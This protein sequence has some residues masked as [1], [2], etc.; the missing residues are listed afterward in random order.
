MLRR[1]GGAAARADASGLWMGAR[2]WARLGTSGGGTRGSQACASARVTF[3]CGM[4]RA[5]V[6]PLALPV[7]MA[8][9]PRGL[10]QPPRGGRR[11]SFPMRARVVASLVTAW[12]LLAVAMPLAEAM[13]AGAGVRVPPRAM[14]AGMG[15]P[16]VEAC[17]LAMTCAMRT[18]RRHRARACARGVRRAV[19][20]RAGQGATRRPSAANGA[21]CG[22]S[23]SI[24]TWCRSSRLAPS[25]P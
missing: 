13:R 3:V 6:A 11:R 2:R 9:S 16:L 5:R 19:A 10:R 14:A 18:S 17:R 4:A 15:V 1:A 23:A 7:V 8:R 21:A 22:P 20:C 24:A 25:A 12:G